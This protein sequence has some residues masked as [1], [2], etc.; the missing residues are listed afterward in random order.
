MKNYAKNNNNLS[1]QC[2]R[3]R[4][5]SPLDFQGMKNNLRKDEVDCSCSIFYILSIN[6]TFWMNLISISILLDALL[7]AL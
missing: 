6:N 7:T 2:I 5:F 4:Y 1:N 3:S